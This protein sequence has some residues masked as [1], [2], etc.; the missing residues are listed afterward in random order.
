MLLKV[1]QPHPRFPPISLSGTDCRLNCLH[2]SRTYLRGMLPAKTD[3]ELLATFRALKAEGA[4]GVLLSGGSTE[5]GAILNLKDSVD[6]IREAKAE[7]GL[8]LNLHPGLM[9]APT[10]MA[11]GG[12]IDVASLEIPGPETI[13]E[14]FRLDAT[15]EDY[16]MTYDR[17]WAAGI[18]VVPHVSIYEGNEDRL[19][20]PLAPSSGRPTPEAIVVI[21][22]TPTRNTP[23]GA[24]P[25]PTP[26]YVGGAIARIKDAFPNSEIALGCMRPR[27]LELRVAV[28]LAALNAGVTRI[29]LP[30]RQTLAAAQEQ[31]YELARLD[32]CCALPTAL[33]ERARPL[34]NEAD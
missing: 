14:V 25:A 9:D 20:T 10:A 33:E 19:L 17:L 32:A 30:T 24:T 6:V 23:M 21:V 34:T 28:E 15:V 18:P 5:E 22:F 12:V 7:T 1:Y 4:I 31:G 13:H 8:I 16:V 2:C 27:T 11:L 26:E 3:E 29:E